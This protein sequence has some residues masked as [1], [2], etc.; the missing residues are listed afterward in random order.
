[1]VINSGNAVTDSLYAMFGAAS[2]DVAD[3]VAIQKKYGAKTSRRKP[4]LA[5]V[6]I[7]QFLDADP[8]EPTPF[9]FYLMAGKSFKPHQ[10]FIVNWLW[11]VCFVPHLGIQGALLCADMGLGKTLSGIAFMQLYK[12]LWPPQQI[13]WPGLVVCPLNLAQ[14]W[15]D[16]GREFFGRGF[17]FLI[18]HDNWHQAGFT[19]SI[20]V[21]DLLQY[22]AIIMTYDSV[23]V[24]AKKH[25][26]HETS[27]KTKSFSKLTAF[28]SYAD[29]EGMQGHE[30]LMRIPWSTIISDESQIFAS[31]KTLVKTLCA[32]NGGP[33]I[34]LS[35]TP[36][37]NKSQDMYYQ[38][39]WLGYTGVDNPKHWNLSVYEAHQCNLRVLVMDYGLA[40]VELP[41]MHEHK[42]FVDFSPAERAQYDNILKSNMQ[43]IDQMEN[44]LAGV[45]FASILV[46]LTRLRQCC[47][48]AY[49][50]TPEAKALQKCPETTQL[51]QDQPG[52]PWINCISGSAGIQSSKLSRMKDIFQQ[53]LI[54]GRR[55]ALIFSNW[56]SSLLIAKWALD[57]ILT[58]AGYYCVLVDGKMPSD[59]F[60]ELLSAFKYDERC[61][62]LL[63]TYKK[64]SV[65]LSSF[66]L[67]MPHCVCAF[68]H[69]DDKL[70]ANGLNIVAATGC[71]CLDPWFSPAVHL[72]ALRRCWRIGQTKEV[73]CWWL[74]ANDTIESRILDICHG[75]TQLSNAFL[76][77]QSEDADDMSTAEGGED[78]GETDYEDGGKKQASTKLN[79]AMIK[80]LL[81]S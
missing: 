69:I 10:I 72:Q 22:D 47:D 53:V 50:I 38:L 56:R 68:L 18:V 63:M 41:P 78:A 42:I 21:Q 48:S 77:G 46:L 16:S 79:I 44:G 62:G 34:C 27:A 49:L 39:H 25:C 37:R 66:V 45:S 19:A 1:M 76:H 26:A 9:P 8:T 75:K 60:E 5:N 74:Y 67:F 20:R 4:G 51:P 17:R 73:D 23:I 59:R 11:D 52:A 24:S 55:K 3:A 58:A 30:V 35:G 29:A 31:G 40:Q 14:P 65:S 7:P 57:P 15:L 81:R 43:A 28:T 2:R 32:L 6:Q 71:I 61:L 70:R 54:P 36:I 33:R 64:G 13:R 80:K 12:Y